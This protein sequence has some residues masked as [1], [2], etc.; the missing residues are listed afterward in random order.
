MRGEALPPSD[1]LDTLRQNLEAIIR[2]TNNLTDA[3]AAAEPGPERW[4]V[5]QIVGHLRACAD[6]WEEAIRAM[7]EQDQPRIRA[8]NPRGW[9]KKTDYWDQPFSRSLAEF[10]SQ[11]DSLLALLEGLSAEQWLRGGAIYGAGNALERDVHFYAQWLARHERSH[12]KEIDR[13]STWAQA[14]E[15]NDP[16]A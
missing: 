13:I 6:K 8:I 9:I 14:E 7:L 10:R 15:V 5:N 12:L 3:Q 1:V 4:S 16:V 11:R 2:S